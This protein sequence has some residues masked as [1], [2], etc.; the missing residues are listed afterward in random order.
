MTEDRPKS[1]RLW[2]E[3]AEEVSKEHDSNKVAELSEELIDALDKQAKQSE[4]MAKR[5]EQKVHGNSTAF[6]PSLWREGIHSSRATVL[7]Q[8]RMKP[9]I[10][11]FYLPK[12]IDKASKPRIVIRRLIHTRVGLTSSLKELLTW[13]F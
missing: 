3:I 8:L 6:L 5:H 13:A 11:F 10:I 12:G 9:S 2:Q 7:A 4:L 1:E